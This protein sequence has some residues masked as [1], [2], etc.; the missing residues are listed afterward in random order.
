[1]RLYDRANMGGKMIE[2]AEDC[3]DIMDCFYTSDIH[4]CRVMNGQWLLYEQPN[5]RGRTYYL[6][7]GEYRKFSD[8]GGMTPRI[9]SLKR[10]T[11]FN[12]T[13]RIV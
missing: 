9:G 4:S 13:T 10:I 8:W 3:P 11:S 6:G 7:P 2:L 12:Y 5:Y 1:M